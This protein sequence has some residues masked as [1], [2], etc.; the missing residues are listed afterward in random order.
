[1]HGNKNKYSADF[2]IDLTNLNQ[3][4]LIV[5]NVIY[6]TNSK[7]YFYIIFLNGKGAN[8]G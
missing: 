1:M 8:Y 5:E 4:T 3:Y 6:L 2:D 7:K